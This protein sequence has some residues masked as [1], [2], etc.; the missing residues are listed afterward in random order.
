MKTIRN[1]LENRKFRNSIIYPRK[2]N[3]PLEIDSSLLLGSL[4]R[5]RGNGR[6]EG[7]L[8][9]PEPSIFI[10]KKLYHV[11]RRCLP[12]IEKV[13]LKLFKGDR[14][15]AKAAVSVFVKGLAA[16]LRLL[17]RKEAFL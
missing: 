13:L 1:I 5:V 16:P 15:K 4:V 2:L 7:F 10:H 6:A 14:G 8:P 17:D 3:Y 12:A 11:R 9:S